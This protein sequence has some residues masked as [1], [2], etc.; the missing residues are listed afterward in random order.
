MQLAHP[1]VA[2]GVAEHSGFESD[3]FARLR[4][5]LDAS[6]TIVFGTEEHA[7]ETA[8]VI[9][10]VH[11]RVRGDG[12][13]ATDP[14]LLLW[15]HSTLVDTAMRIHSRF[16]GGLSPEDQDEYYRQSMLVAELLG[17]PIELQPPDL[18]SFRAYVRAMVGT[19]EVT[20]EARQLARSIL[21]PKLP[22]VA[23]PFVELGRQV[24]VGLLP[25]P[26]RR[27]YRLSWDR[28]RQA[29]MLTAG[30]VARQVLPRLPGPLRRVA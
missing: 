24:T 14:Q 25:P 9:D 19:L 22:W 20:D 1:M 11:Q 2:R 8:A 26:L 4:A 18:A 23:E 7:R 28:P 10:A 30:L 21:H 16:L 12:Y 5:T 6:Y 27:Q 3:P 13:H 15:V 29:A 17:V